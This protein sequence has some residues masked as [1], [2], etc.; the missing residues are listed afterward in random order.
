MS[1]WTEQDVLLYLR[2]YEIPY[3]SV[4]GAI[5]TDDHGKLYTTGE[6]R[7]GCVFCMFGVHLEDE[8]N[9]FQRLAVTHPKLYEY[10]MRDFDEGGLGLAAVLDYIGVDYEFR[11]EQLRLEWEEDA[12]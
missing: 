3:A 10:C 8:P 12:G 5:E 1:F 11:G 6:T 2:K 7:T 4:Y 9:R